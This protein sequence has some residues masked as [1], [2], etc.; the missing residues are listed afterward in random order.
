MEINLSK[1]QKYYGKQLVLDIPA[2]HIQPGEMVGVIGNNGAGKTTLFRLFLDLIEASRGEIAIHGRT[3]AG[4][5]HWKTKTGSFL[6]EGFLIDF[7]SP[8][9]FFYFSGKLYGLSRAAVDERLEP[10]G[11]FMNG[12]ILGQQKYIRQFSTG[13]RQKIG[14]IAAVIVQPSLLILDEPFNF[15]DPSSQILIKRI[16]RHE[17]LAR[18]ST[19]L[20]SS[21]N[22]NH[23]TEICNRI[24]LLERGRVIRDIRLPGDDLA[25]I[26]QYFAVNAE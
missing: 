16:L 21:H 14:I 4:S 22:L 9:E 26:E 5:D 18:G 13:N 12:E 1:L 24:I 3:V 17:N 7:L 10:F 2:L 8:E 6:D 25:G 23:I 11:R 19:M 20:L 15:L